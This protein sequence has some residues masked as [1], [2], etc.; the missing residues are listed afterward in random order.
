ML[1][2]AVS[3]SQVAFYEYALV[4]YNKKHNKEGYCEEAGDRMRNT[5]TPI[6]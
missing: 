5:S 2:L 4:T 1:Q 3:F 6:S